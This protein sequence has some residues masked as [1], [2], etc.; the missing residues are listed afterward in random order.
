MTHVTCRMTAKN[1][2]QLRNPTLGNRL[3]AT[4]TFLQFTYMLTVFLTT[5]LGLAAPRLVAAGGP[6]DRRLAARLRRLP[7]RPRGRLQPRQPRPRRSRPCRRWYV[8]PTAAV[9]EICSRTNKQT[10]RQTDRRACLS[11]YSAPSAT[12]WSTPA[13]S[14]W[15]EKV[16]TR[17]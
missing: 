15:S 8:S 11:Q 5:Q 4:F 6:V 1:R 3:L 10:D 7:Q 14:T 2:D 12:S 16:A 9:L 17:R 13:A